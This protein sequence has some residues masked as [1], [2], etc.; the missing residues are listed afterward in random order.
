MPFNFEILPEELP[1]VKEND[2]STPEDSKKTPKDQVDV[3]Q[4]S[5]ILLDPK[6]RGS[7]INYIERPTNN[8]ILPLK[9]FFTC[10]RPPRS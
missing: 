1:Q 9:V 5:K 7:S 6:K 4:N 10:H 3:K 2:E 8:I